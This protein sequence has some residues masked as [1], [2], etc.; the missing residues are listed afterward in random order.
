MQAKPEALIVFALALLAVILGVISTEAPLRREAPSGVLLCTC[1]CKA[2]QIA[3]ESQTT[4][5]ESLVF[6]YRA[7]L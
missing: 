7:A 3:V 4:P 1:W 2:H 6:G 5:T